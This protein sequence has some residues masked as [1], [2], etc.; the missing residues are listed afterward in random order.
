[1]VYIPVL[2]RVGACGLGDLPILPLVQWVCELISLCNIL[3]LNL[4]LK[5]NSA[6]RRGHLAVMCLLSLWNF[7]FVCFH[8]WP[9]EEDGTKREGRVCCAHTFPFYRQLCHS[10]LVNFLPQ[11]CFNLAVLISNGLTEL[12]RSNSRLLKWE[13]HRKVITTIAYWITTEIRKYQNC[14]DFSTTNSLIS[15]IKQKRVQNRNQLA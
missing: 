5:N 4:F 6:Q 1:M 8:S 12:N 11:N 15:Y 3:L 9:A 7:L 2:T 14:E 13:H 10:H